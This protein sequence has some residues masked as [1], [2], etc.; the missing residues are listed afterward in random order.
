MAP[1]VV[2]GMRRADDEWADSELVADSDLRDARETTS[3]QDA[4]GTSRD[5]EALRSAEALE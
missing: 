4:P 1:S 3:A 5:D 2:L